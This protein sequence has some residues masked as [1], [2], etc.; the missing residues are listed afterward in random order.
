MMIFSRYRLNFGKKC[1]NSYFEVFVEKMQ[2]RCG[3]PIYGAKVMLDIGESGVKK[4][5]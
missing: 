4:L 3:L 1:K 2:S 5:N